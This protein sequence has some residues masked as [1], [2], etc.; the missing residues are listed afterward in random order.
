M[1]GEVIAELEHV[2]VDFD[3]ERVLD[4]VDLQIRR[5]DFLGVIGPNGAGKTT[6]LRVLVGL[7]RP[8]CGHVRL[9]GQDVR[10]FRQWH[11][12]GYV[13]QKAVAFET[14][15]PATVLEVVLSGRAGRVGAGRRFRPEDRTAAV[16]A[17]RTVG[18]WEVRDRLVGRLSVG[19][20]QRVFVA[21]ALANE[22]ELLLLDEPTVGVDPE[23]EER[24]YGLLHRLNQERGTTVVL[25]SH[26]VA[27]VAREVS[28]LA[29]L[30]RTLFF[31]GPPEEAL[32][33][34]TLEKL[35]GTRSLLVTHRH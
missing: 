30:N 31:H 34:G 14:R 27:A 23:G 32:R 15:F 33:A 17:L 20:Q 10:Q 35:Y 18:L 28:Q 11:R 5:G 6:L 19:Q 21:R 26:D 8:S 12:V 2:C 9:F 4:R 3:G 1:A 16:V 29:C 24:F 7:V 25:V 13:P 22:P